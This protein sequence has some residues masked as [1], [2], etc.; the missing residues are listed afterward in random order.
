MLKSRPSRRPVARLAARDVT[1]NLRAKSEQRELIDRAAGL[2]GRNRTEF[3]LDVAC[4][5]ADNVLL[6]RRLFFLDGE[7]HGR[8][9]AALD[10]PPADNAR[11]RRLLT[12]RAPLE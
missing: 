6:D 3:I 8:F 12:T 2:L 1:I 11:L 5:E 7:A 9:M 10:A 4:R